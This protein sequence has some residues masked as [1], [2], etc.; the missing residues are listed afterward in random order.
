MAPEGKTS[1]V[2]ELFCERTDP[3]WQASD[4]SI[5]ELVTQDLAE[6]LQFI[7]PREVIGGFAVRSI[8]AYPRYHVG[9]QDAVEGIKQHLGSFENLSIVGRGGTFR[10]NNTDHSIETGLLAAR[11]VLGESHDLSSVN[12]EQEYHEERRVVAEGSGSVAV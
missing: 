9:Y 12:S 7:E 1:L 4:Q 3:V 8:D 6:K 2:L 10:Y 5:C 11:N